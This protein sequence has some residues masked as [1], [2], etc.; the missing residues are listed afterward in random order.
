MAGLFLF[1]TV[2]WGAFSLNSRLDGNT[3]NWGSRSRSKFRRVRVWVYFSY[4][5]CKVL[6]CTI[7]NQA[8]ENMGLELRREIRAWGTDLEVN[9]KHLVIQVMEKN[10]IT[11]RDHVEWN[12]QMAIECYSTW[13]RS[14][15]D[16]FVFWMFSLCS[17]MCPLQSFCR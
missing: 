11:Q 5:E 4:M 15:P 7:F 3:F 2:S 12:V 17:I 6:Q 16:S 9:G 14:K 10:E 8:D 13:C 1:F